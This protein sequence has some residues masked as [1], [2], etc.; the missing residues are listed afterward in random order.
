[1]VSPDDVINLYKLLSHH[2]IRVWL[3]GGWGID[4][5]LGEHTRPHKDLDVIMLVDDVNRLCELLS[6]KDGYTLKELW[7]ENL[8]TIDANGIKTAT[9]FVLRDANG[10]ELDAHAMRLDDQG[11]GQPAWEKREAFIYTPQDLVGKGLIAG[12]PVHCM[13][14]DNQMICHTGYQLPEYQWHDLDLLREKFGI[15][16][17]A[18]LSSQGVGR[19]PG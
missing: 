1:M 15:A 17:P 9:A 13:S 19:D 11:Y 18:E 3:T 6:K 4:A 14:A 2:G 7:S 16:F 12:F 10:R 8:W 5:L